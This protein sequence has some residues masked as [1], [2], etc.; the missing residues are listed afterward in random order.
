MS[1]AIHVHAHRSWICMLSSKRAG[2]EWFVSFKKATLFH[3]FTHVNFK[4]R[5]TYCRVASR[6]E[7]P[8]PKELDSE[9]RS[10]GVFGPTR[11]DWGQT[12]PNFAHCP[13]LE[14]Q[15]E[16]PN[17]SYVMR[18]EVQVTSKVV[19]L[20]TFWRQLRTKL[21]GN[22]TWG[23]LL[24]TKCHACP[25]NVGNTVKTGVRISYWP[26]MSPMFKPCGPQLGPKLPPGS[27]LGRS[28]GLVGRNWPKVW[29]RCCGRRFAGR[30]GPF[31]ETCKLVPWVRS[32]VHFLAPCPGEREPQPEAVPVWRI[33]PVAPT[34]TCLGIFGA[35]SRPVIAWR[36][37]HAFDAG[38]P[39]IRFCIFVPN[40][41]HARSHTHTRDHSLPIFSGPMRVRILVIRCGREWFQFH[42]VCTILRT[43]HCW[44]GCAIARCCFQM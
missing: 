10:G 34:P 39:T 17:W 33:C 15:W 28:W 35:A 24:K 12:W 37:K 16:H 21:G 1:P 31:C 6:R 9:E 40:C 36:K 41:W 25:K 5:I 2:H 20:G 18:M 27:K 44:N 26:V 43:R 11:A 19:Q 29:S 23:T 32:P 13:H 8:A 14:P 3:G 7:P 4:Y 22:T 42:E 38:G 30:F